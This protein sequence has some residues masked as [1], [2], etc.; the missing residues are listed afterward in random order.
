VLLRTN[1]SP[2][3]IDIS[4]YAIES[5]GTGIELPSAWRAGGS[6]CVGHAKSSLG[7]GRRLAHH[8]RGSVECLHR[9]GDL[10]ASFDGPGRVCILA[11]ATVWAS[12]GASEWFVDLL[13]ILYARA[14]GAVSMHAA[15]VQIDGEAVIIGG[16]SGAGKTTTSTAL[17]RDGHVLLTDEM[18]ML[19]RSHEDDVAG[20]GWLT[21]PRFVGAAPATLADLSI[22]PVVSCRPIAA[23]D[24]VLPEEAVN[25]LRKKKGEY[26]LEL[27]DARR[28][29]N[30][31]VHPRCVVVL[32][33]LA[34]L[35]RSHTWTR[36]A[37]ESAFLAIMGLWLDPTIASRSEELM[38]LTVAI[39]HRCPTYELSLGPELGDLSDV[40]HAIL[41][42]SRS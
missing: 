14:R 5:A 34:H 7:P 17:Y 27:A 41:A 24:V 36:L 37:D 13:Q 35:T 10:L 9:P 39:Q 8:Q 25:R 26:D 31:E 15:C 42:E 16:S 22:T 19:F 32:R 6:T 30:R 28:F 18:L 40:F 21:R 20:V 3:C 1:R 29:V 2:D 4:V 38:D 11:N 12:D 33:S 23:P